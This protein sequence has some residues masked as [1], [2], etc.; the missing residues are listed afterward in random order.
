[1]AGT[2]DFEGV[3][4]GGGLRE[5]QSVSKLPFELITP[6]LEEQVAA[7]LAHGAKKYAPNNWKR[8]MPFMKSN[9]GSLRR[10]IHAWAKGEDIDPES[11]LPHLAHAACSIMFLMY[12]QAHPELYGKF[13]DREGK[14]NAQAVSDSAELLARSMPSH[15]AGCAGARG[16][17]GGQYVFG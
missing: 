15:V 6:E 14:K 3:V 11:G 1:M 8:G 17:D 9:Y 2:K 4:D 7:V 13:D 12:Y 5:C 10:H 16:L